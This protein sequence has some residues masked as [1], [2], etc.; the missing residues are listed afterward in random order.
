MLRYLVGTADLALVFD[1][2]S[3]GNP[4]SFADAAYGD[5]VMD[6]KSTYGHTLLLG[7]GAVIWM[8]KKQRSVVTS[9]MEAEYSP[10]C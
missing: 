5:D 1:H 9:T 7:N 3:N 6:R 4:V 8:S 2:S 10:M